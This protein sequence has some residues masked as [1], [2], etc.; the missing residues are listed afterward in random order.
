MSILTVQYIYI[1]IFYVFEGVPVAI[2]KLT[3]KKLPDLMLTTERMASH[4]T[5]LS[6]IY[7][8]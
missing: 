6:N 1:Y 7:V 3:W 2:R 8:R 4:Q 5:K